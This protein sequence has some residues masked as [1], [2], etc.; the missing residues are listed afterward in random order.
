MS[1]VLEYFEGQAIDYQ[2]RSRKGLWAFLRNKEKAAVLDALNPFQ[3]MSCLELG[4]G[5]GYYTSFLKKLNPSRLVAVDFSQRMLS[6]L[7]N[8]LVWRV[9]AD[10]EDFSFK[11]SFD[12]IVC[13]GALEF[14]P[15]L[16]AFLRCSGSTLSRDGHLILLLPKKGFS[17]WFYKLFHKSHGFEIRLFD[18]KELKDTL[19]KNGLKIDLL[20]EPTPMTY[21]LRASHA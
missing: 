20:R 4:C 3:G 21:V 16:A 19:G 18:Q 12:R 14:L 9:C 17:G 7:N 6:S 10:I 1:S 15:D 2:I 8:E 5:S 11:V 13:A